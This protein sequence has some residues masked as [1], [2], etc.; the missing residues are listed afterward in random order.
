MGKAALAK[1]RMRAITDLG[2]T[3]LCS[4]A[5]RGLDSGSGRMLVRRVS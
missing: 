3:H 5:W 2:G 1:L 4:N